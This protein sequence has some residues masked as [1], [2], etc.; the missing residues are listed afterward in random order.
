MLLC[1][2]VDNIRAYIVRMSDDADTNDV[3]QVR[4]LRRVFEESTSQEI[5]TMQEMDRN[6][7]EVSDYIEQM[8][9][10]FVKK[11]S[12]IKDLRKTIADPTT[13]RVTSG[14]S[15]AK[16][17]IQKL[18]KKVA[19]KAKDIMR[20]RK[21]VSQRDLQLSMVG[22]NAEENSVRVKELSLEI[23]TK[24]RLIE[25][26]ER[27]IIE[28]RE[29]LE[30]K[31]R[32]IDN[33]LSQSTELETNNSVDDMNEKVEELR[34][35]IMEKDE[36][37]G[38]LNDIITQLQKDRSEKEAEDCI[39]RQ[40]SNTMKIRQLEP[41]AKHSPEIEELLNKLRQE[42]AIIVQRLVNANANNC[43]ATNS[44]VSASSRS[45]DKPFRG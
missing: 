45:P 43:Q 20:L 41:L 4:E 34:D 17:M 16:D 39:N 7:C 31:D 24:Q 23:A 42:T 22:R 3:T 44:I 1:L 38:R 33:Q 10:F 11:S 2:G 27:R 35:A 12:E 25:E 29:G 14:Y 32:T 6:M 21:D 26:M 28:L 13:G 18:E 40:L 36:I 8:Q 19:E 9:R 37:I 5:R 30:K 15:M